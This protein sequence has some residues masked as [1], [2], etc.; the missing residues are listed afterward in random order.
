MA[1]FKKVGGRN[2][3][4][5]KIFALSTCGWCKKT[6][7]YLNAHN[8]SYSY[9]DVDL[10]SEE[11]LEPVREEQLRFNPSGSYPTIVVDSDYCIIGFDEEQ[12]Q[13]LAEG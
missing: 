12:L 8:V 13:Q 6:K 2:L 1:E 9:I 11:E 4:D 7:A 3:G 5:I 10:L